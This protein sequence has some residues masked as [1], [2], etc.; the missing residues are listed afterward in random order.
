MKRQDLRASIVIAA[1]WLLG[2]TAYSILKPP[3]FSGH[4]SAI[5]NANDAVPASDQT[6]QDE[7]APKHNKQPVRWAHQ[8]WGAV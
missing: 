5:Y 2:I 1:A 8:R 3:A 7:R 6:F 4:E